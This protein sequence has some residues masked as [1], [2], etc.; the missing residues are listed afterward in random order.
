M[1]YGPHVTD[2]RTC[3]DKIA[4]G[5]RLKSYRL[6]AIDVSEVVSA[7]Y[8]FRPLQ[9]SNPWPKVHRFGRMTSK[10]CPPVAFA[11]PDPDVATPGASRAA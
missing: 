7:S 5:V 4:V 10:R 3:W 11:G 6:I 9:M 8:R 1:R 2:R